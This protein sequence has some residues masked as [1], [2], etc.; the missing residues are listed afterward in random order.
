[1][2]EETRQLL[3]VFANLVGRRPTE[4]EMARLLGSVLPQGQVARGLEAPSPSVATTAA[5]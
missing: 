3:I 1:M 2:L 4:L 5:R